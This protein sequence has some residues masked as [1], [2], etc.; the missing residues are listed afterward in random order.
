MNSKDRIL[1]RINSILDK[2]INEGEAYLT[3]I[4]L[5]ESIYG[6]DSEQLSALKTVYQNIYETRQD[7]F[8]RDYDV[9]EF[10]KGSL[11]ALKAHI[12]SGLIESIQSQARSE[13]LG[14][15]VALARQSYNAE[16]KNVAAVL[17]S[18]A[19]EDA[20]KRCATE[21][22][23]DVQGKDMSNVVDALKSNNI[24]PNSQAETLNRYRHFRNKALHAEWGEIDSPTVIGVIEFTDEFLE[25]GKYANRKG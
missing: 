19:L 24:I 11:R 13:V 2:L 12:E 21:H 15:F 18:A 14:D 8:N 9:R 25:E 4:D 7:E 3:A 1:D 5:F 20:L 17:I 16:R 10:L 6:S 23:L 22:G